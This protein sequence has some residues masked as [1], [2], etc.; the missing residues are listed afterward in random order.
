MSNGV[1][2]S[3][4]DT[5]KSEFGLPAD[6]EATSPSPPAPAEVHIEEEITDSCPVTPVTPLCCEQ[7]QSEGEEI[8]C[9]GVHSS[10]NNNN[11]TTKEPVVGDINNIEHPRDLVNVELQ[12]T[13]ADLSIL[14]TTD[15]QT[16][17][18]L[19]SPHLTKL[20][21]FQEATPSDIDRPV[22]V[23]EVGMYRVD[24]SD[25]PESIVTNGHSSESS[26][27]DESTASDSVKVDITALRKLASK[28]FDVVM[29]LESGEKR[30]GFSVI[31]GID[32]GFPP[33]VESIAGG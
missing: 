4:P 15:I 27:K 23:G 30:F 7:Q 2:T 17:T 11:N 25:K 13:I 1:L 21:N 33:R 28:E 19:S 14:D 9:N 29:K 18:D 6:V 24:T 20:D 5:V 12:Y 10:N 26:T 31:G 8:Q 16:T 3:Q 22:S 32:E